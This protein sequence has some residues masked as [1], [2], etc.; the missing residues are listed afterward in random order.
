VENSP[1]AIQKAPEI[2]QGL[3]SVL[4]VGFRLFAGL[5]VLGLFFSMVRGKL[6]RQERAQM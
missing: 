6:R 4:R 2:G 1:E 5:S 3:I